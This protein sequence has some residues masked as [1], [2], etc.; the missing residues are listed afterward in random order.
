MRCEKISSKILWNVLT[1]FDMIL[2]RCWLLSYEAPQ[3]WVLKLHVQKGH[4]FCSFHREKKVLQTEIVLCSLLTQMN[5]MQLSSLPLLAHC[6]S[7]LFIFLYLFSAFPFS[8]E[9]D[10][11]FPAYPTFTCSVLHPS[12]FSMSFRSS[13]NF[14]ISFILQTGI[15]VFSI[16]QS[17]CLSLF[18]IITSYFHLISST[19]HSWRLLYR[20]S[21]KLQMT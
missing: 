2:V 14:S 3:W 20:S 16:Y 10:L 21:Y 15:R 12:L 9:V 18:F 13:Y 17:F 4:V 5:I 11:L 19:H 1:I 6:Y 8:T 7:I